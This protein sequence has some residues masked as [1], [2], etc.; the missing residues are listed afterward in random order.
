MSLDGGEDGLDY[1]KKIALTAQNYL[2]KGGAIVV[3][4]GHD[5]AGDVKAIFEASGW[6]EISVFKDMS[7]SDRM[8]IAF[9]G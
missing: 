6:K 8:V 3:E 5:Q 1:Y 7:G 4:I 2:K 9:K